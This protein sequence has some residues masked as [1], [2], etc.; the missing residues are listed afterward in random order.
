MLVEIR[1]QKLN[2]AGWSYTKMSRRAQDWATVA[3]ASGHAIARRAPDDDRAHEHGR[4]TAS[5]D[6]GRGCAR[7]WRH[8]CRCRGARRRGNRAVLGSRCER[9]LP[10]ASGT[11]THAPRAR[12]VVGEVVRP[13]TSRAALQEGGCARPPAAISQLA[14][15]VG[16]LGHWNLLEHRAQHVVRRE[17]VVDDDAVAED[18]RRDLAHV[19]D[20]DLGSAG[21]TRVR[22]RGA[23]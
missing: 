10:P 17:T 18:V 12:R 5:G 1:V 3:V 19:L 15:R 14:Q 6:R 7:R 16:G 8:Q 13:G 21:Q 2:G 20:R 23:R 11:G 4:D 22:L 9:G